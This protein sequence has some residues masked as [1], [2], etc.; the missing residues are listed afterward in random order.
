MP[1]KLKSIFPAKKSLA[2]TTVPPTDEITQNKGA[3]TAVP[4]KQQDELIANDVALMH[5]YF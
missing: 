1:K 5:Q 3:I 4:S 2:A